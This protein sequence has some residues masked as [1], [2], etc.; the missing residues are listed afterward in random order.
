MPKFIAKSS[1][2]KEL[3]KTAQIIS[4]L[5]INALIIGNE[6]T[7]KTLLSKEILPGAIVV[8]GSDFKA[9]KSVIENEESF[10][11]ENFHKIV[12]YENLDFSAKKVVGTSTV[13]MDKNIIDKFFGITLEIPDL[14]KRKEDLK[15]IIEKFVEQAETT[16]LT[17]VSFDFKNFKPDL[18]KNCHSLKKDIFLEIMS[19]SLNENDIVKIL[20]KFLSDR[21]DGNNAYRENLV[22]FDKAIIEEGL[23]LYGSQLKLSEVLGLNR[24]TLR[25]KVAEIDG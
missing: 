16:L 6:G 1:I 15:P 20:K 4:N 2:S 5:N 12:N 23:E 8:D 18:S 14:L 22:T 13:K 7:G 3:V 9:L 11:I 19:D 24:N 17:K 25:K 21:I 10:I